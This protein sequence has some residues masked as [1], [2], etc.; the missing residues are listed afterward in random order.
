MSQSLLCKSTVHAQD[1]YMDFAGGGT[2][3]FMTT[4]QVTTCCYS[5]SANNAALI[6]IAFEHDYE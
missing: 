4:I 2:S 1:T 3:V 5:D 6:V